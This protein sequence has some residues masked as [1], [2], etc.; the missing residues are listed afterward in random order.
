[1]SAWSVRVTLAAAF[2]CLVATG[3]AATPLRPTGSIAFAAWSGTQIYTTR[4]DGTGRRALTFDPW[5]DRQPVKSRDGRRI[6]YVVLRDEEGDIWVMNADGS[7]QHAVTSGPTD[8]GH[9]S[10]SPDGR[11][12][13]FHRDAGE[14]EDI[15]VMNAD[16]SNVRRLTTAPERDRFPSWSPDGR[17]I[18]F[19]RGDASLAWDVYVMAADGT[20]QRPLTTDP[21]D[22]Y[23]ARWSRDGRRI[24]FV[25]VRA[26]TPDIWVMDADGGLPRQVTS[27]ECV[28]GLPTWSPDSA[29]ILFVRVECDEAGV[30][31]VGADGS[32]LRALPAE[33]VDE[34]SW[35]ADG[36]IV[37]ASHKG[38]I[39]DIQV[40]RVDG[41]GRRAVADTDH[42][43]LEPEWSPDG[44]RIAFSMQASERENI[45]VAPAAGGAARAVTRHPAAD[46]DPAWSPDGRRI[47][48]RT[49][50]GSR[51]VAFGHGR[52]SEIFLVSLAGGRERNLTRSPTDEADPDWS[53]DGRQ[54]AFSRFPPG[55][56]RFELDQRRGGDI[57]TLN[58]TG[59]GLRR[60]TTN[61]A[62]DENPS[63]SPDG[64]RIAFS[65]AR[66]GSRRIWLMRADGT[67]Q[68]PLTP[69]TRYDDAQPDWSPDGKFIAFTRFDENEAYVYVVGADGRG[70]RRVAVVCS[71]AFCALG[72]SP[73]WRPRR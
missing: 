18:L 24:A 41:N 49:Y 9:P 8:D 4:P 50:R 31:V 47:A 27:G 45:Y 39:T 5:F 43:E 26:G 57:F 60:L 23:T 66:T 10:W 21:V 58:V 68:R 30:Y 56:T 54:I 17:S 38:T 72:G 1:M 67:G 44:R 2:M 37:F 19:H 33:R 12:L 64:R 3:D 52:D 65:S 16:G 53:P 71:N 13:V 6:A 42:S 7:G 40:A 22:D 48:F 25:S 69:R 55:M 73:S 70:L 15:Y 61:P 62:D 28:D 32:G 14:S 34:P 20:G 46:V 11:R 63:W 29:Q 35:S 51:R 59:S 36:T